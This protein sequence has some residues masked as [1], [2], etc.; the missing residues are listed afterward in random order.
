MVVSLLANSPGVY[1]PVG[2]QVTNWAVSRGPWSPPPATGMS[3]VLRTSLRRTA[4]E[5]E[6]GDGRGI[7]ADWAV[8][9]GR[10]EKCGVGGWQ[11]GFPAHE[12]N[13]RGWESEE[14][15]QDYQN[16]QWARK[17]GRLV[18]AARDEAGVLQ[19]Q[20]KEFAGPILASF[21]G[22]WASSFD[23]WASS[24]AAWAS[25][26]AFRDALNV[27]WASQDEK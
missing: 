22:I 18:A 26:M 4:W 27:S 7:S 24:D 25:S 15:R 23:I 21:V 9:S 2:P 19:G 5:L 20:R 3:P 12:A 17:G 14:N 1:R 13:R 10:I 6:G 11:R 8:I 16:F